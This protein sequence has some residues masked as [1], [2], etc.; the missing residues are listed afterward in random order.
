MAFRRTIRP[1]SG[2]YGPRLRVSTFEN[3]HCVNLELQL[4]NGECL[5]TDITRGSTKKLIAALRA[6]AKSLKP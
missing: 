1:F 3:E 5:D 6:A 4:R 2:M